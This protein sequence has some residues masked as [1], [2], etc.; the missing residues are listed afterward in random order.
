MGKSVAFKCQIYMYT[1]VY[2]YIDIQYISIYIYT[3][4]TIYNVYYIH[5]ILYSHSLK[6]LR[7]LLFEVHENEHCR[8]G[9]KATSFIDPTIGT[10]VLVYLEV[11]AFP[12][13]HSIP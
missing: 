10:D 11:C 9:L 12:T 1:Y 7:P 13:L 3:V 4:Y 5:S 2:I 8:T 6:N